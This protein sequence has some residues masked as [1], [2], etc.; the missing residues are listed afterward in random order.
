M[1]DG[2][3]GIC[4]GTP[5]KIQPVVWLLKPL[6]PK[7]KKIPIFAGGATLPHPGGALGH[8]LY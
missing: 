4:M 1:L 6:P 7:K 3:D 2:I 8:G 5:K